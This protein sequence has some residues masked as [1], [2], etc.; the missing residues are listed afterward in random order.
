MNF[1]TKNGFYLDLDCLYDT[2]LATLELLDHR[3]AKMAIANGYYKRTRDIFPFVD[4]KTFNE[5]YALRDVSTLDKAI[6]TSALDVLANFTKDAVRQVNESPHSDE[7]NVFLNVYPYKI[8][9]A[10]AQAM[11]EPLSKLTGKVANINLLN[12]PVEKVSLKFCRENLSLMMMYDFEDWLEFNAKN[13]MFRSYPIP[14]VCLFVPELFIVDGPVD[15]EE[16]KSMIQQGTHPFRAVEKMARNL[17]DLT[18]IDISYY[19]ARIPEAIIDEIKKEY[20]NT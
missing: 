16:I 7:I 6:M 19:C 3:L 18:M 14:D 12:I 4:K 13:D 11:L 20:E 2:R 9:R 15:E 8:D 17:I 5:L 10:T 1:E